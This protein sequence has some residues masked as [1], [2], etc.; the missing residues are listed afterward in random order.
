MTAG[1]NGFSTSVSIQIPVSFVRDRI[2]EKIYCY[3]LF[4]GA[5][6]EKYRT[7]E[8][9]GQPYTEKIFFPYNTCKLNKIK[10]YQSIPSSLCID[11]GIDGDDQA[12]L[13]KSMEKKK[14]R[15]MYFII[16]SLGLLF[17]A[18]V[19]TSIMN[20][21][22]SQNPTDIRA[23]AGVNTGVRY[24]AVISS[25]EPDGSIKV[26]NVTPSG[27]PDENFGSWTVIPAGTIN[28]AGITAGTGIVLTVDASTFDIKT[29]TMQA[30]AINKK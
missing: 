6:Q 10:Q 7:N 5:I 16:G 19:I 13:N 18:V 29:H 3:V 9:V 22:Q 2:A 21:A 11:N 12:W 4:Y 23:K 25:L 1:E 17:L 30:K 27:N 20:N 15:S 8:P 14:D 24:E 28:M 26:E